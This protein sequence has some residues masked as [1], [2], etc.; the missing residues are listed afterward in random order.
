MNL[1][2]YLD[3]LVVYEKYIL[4]GVMFLLFLFLTTFVIINMRMKRLVKYYQT[5]LT[6]A[7]GKNLEEMLYASFEQSKG[8]IARVEEITK[9]TELLQQQLNGCWQKAG[10]IRFNAFEDVG[11]E[12]SFA[13]ALLN[14]NLDGFIISNLYGRQESHVYLRPIGQ[15]KSTQYL[16]PEEQQALEQAIK[17]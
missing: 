11:G 17:A 2:H 8:A 4:L 10:M 12:M 14:Q 1:G 3:L 15:G 16:L 5:M 7:E 9:K 13:L 6:G